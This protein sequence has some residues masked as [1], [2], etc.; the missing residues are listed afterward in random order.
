MKQWRYKEIVKEHVSIRESALYFIS[1]CSRATPDL[2]RPIAAMKLSIAY[3][4][5][6]ADA[7]A[8]VSEMDC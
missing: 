6:I 2:Y 5:D 1:E 7:I 3:D 4:I 8:V